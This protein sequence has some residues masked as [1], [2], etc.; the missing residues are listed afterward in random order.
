MIPLTDE[1]FTTGGLPR[2][3]YV[4]L[5]TVTSIRHADVQAEEGQL[6]AGTTEAICTLLDRSVPGTER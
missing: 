4:N 2:D 5:W 1:D 6:V 3:S